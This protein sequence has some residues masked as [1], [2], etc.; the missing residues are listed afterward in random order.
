M[1]CWPIWYFHQCHMGFSCPMLS[2]LCGTISGIKAGTHAVQLTIVHSAGLL[3][4]ASRPLASRN[5]MADLMIVLI[6]YH[7][8]GCMQYSIVIALGTFRTDMGHHD[9]LPPFLLWIYTLATWYLEAVF[10]TRWKEIPKLCFK[11]WIQEYGKFEGSEICTNIIEF[12]TK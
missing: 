6:W 7:D 1:R 9:N 4:D 10:E 3:W 11:Y 12:H 5:T 8:Q 2:L